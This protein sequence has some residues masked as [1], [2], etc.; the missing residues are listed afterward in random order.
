MN[1]PSMCTIGGAEGPDRKAA[2]TRPRIRLE[3][4]ISPG[5]TPSGEPSPREPA[6]LLSLGVMFSGNWFLR[7]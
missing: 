7:I 4:Q 5:P 1:T 6:Y 2:V 3:D